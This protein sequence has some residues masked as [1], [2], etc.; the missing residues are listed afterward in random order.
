M[1]RKPN[2]VRHWKQHFDPRADYV[3]LKAMKLGEGE[4]R[5]GD[6]LTQ[7]LRDAHVSDV[8]LKFWWKARV[9]GLAEFYEAPVS[10]PRVVRRGGGW[11]EVTMPGETEPRTVRG[12]AALEQLLAEV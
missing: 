7:E 1:M 9:V 4:V 8:R 6:P 2:R 11:Y 3:F 5:P 10:E 12:S